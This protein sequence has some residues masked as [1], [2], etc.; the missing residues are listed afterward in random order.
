MKKSVMI[1]ISLMII[2]A[3]GIWFINIDRTP[4]ENKE[5]YVQEKI[6]NE[7]KNIILKILSSEDTKFGISEN[8][9][10]TLTSD[11]NLTKEEV[12]SDLIV[13]PTFDY[14]LEVVSNNEFKIKPNSKLERNA[15]YKFSYK[16]V[17]FGK[18]FQTA[19]DLKIFYSY[20]GDGVEDVPLTTGIEIYFNSENIV[21]LENHFTITPQVSG[22]FIYEKGKVIFITKGL[23]RDTIYTVKITSGISTE[24]NERTLEEPYEFTFTTG[25]FSGFINNEKYSV[26]NVLYGS[27]TIIP[28]STWGE[29][30]LYDVTILKSDTFADFKKTYTYYLENQSHGLEFED[31]DLV[32]DEE[33][34]S[35]SVDYVP[36]IDIPNNLEKGSYV[37]KINGDGFMQY[38]FL[39]VGDHQIY[40]AKAVN[41]ELL[42]I[43]D[44]TTSKPVLD[45]EVYLEDNVVGKTNFKGVLFLN[46]EVD[47]S[48]NNDYTVKIENSEY[49]VRTRGDDYGYYDGYYYDP[50]NISHDH[51]AFLY[52]DRSAYQSTDKVNIFGYVRSYTDAKISDAKI[53]VTKYWDDEVYL[54]KSVEVTDDYTITT[55]FDIENFDYGYYNMKFIIDGKIVEFKELFIV[56]YEKPEILLSSSIDKKIIFSGDV[57]NYNLNSSYFNG[58][59]YA[60]FDVKISQG[61]I[62]SYGVDVQIATTDKN[63]NLDLELTPV[64]GNSNWTPISYQIRAE[65]DQA[66]KTYLDIYEYIYVV[67]RNVMIQGSFTEDGSQVILDIETSNIDLSDFNG[68]FGVDYDNIKGSN[69]SKNIEIRVTETYF[70][71]VLDRTVYDKI[72][73]VYQDIYNYKKIDSDLGTYY[74][75]TENGLGKFKF[76]VEPDRNYTFDVSTRD[77]KTRKTTSSFRYGSYYRYDYYGDAQYEFESDGATYSI[78]EA[79]VKN[80]LNYGE[81]IGTKDNDL[82]LFLILR[83]G[84][85]D[86]IVTDEAKIEFEFERYYQPNVLIG[87]VYFDGVAM[88]IIPKYYKMVVEYDN[89]ELELN[90]VAKTDKLDYQPGE[91]VELSLDVIDKYGN[92]INGELN[93][94]V[95]DEAYLSLFEDYFDIGS[96]LHSRDY[97]D[98]LLFEMASSMSDEVGSG[99]ESGEGGDGSFIRADFKDTAAFETIKIVDGKGK[100]SFVLP[101]NLTSWRLT[102]H[103]VNEELYYGSSK[104][105]VN[106]KLPYFIRNLYDTVYLSGDN[107]FINLKSDGYDLN[108]DTPIQYTASIKDSKGNEKLYEKDY[109]GKEFANLPIGKLS[110]GLYELVVTGNSMGLKDGV[111]DEITVKDSFV[112]FKHKKTYSVKEDYVPNTDNGKTE[113]YFY[114]NEAREFQNTVFKSFGYDNIR[115]EEIIARFEAYDIL[116]NNFG[117]SG[118]YDTYELSEYQNWDG[119]LKELPTSDSSVISTSLVAATDYGMKYF[120]KERITEYLSYALVDKKNPEDVKAL[121]LWGLAK[122]NQPVLLGINTFL[123]SKGFEDLKFNSQMYII[124]ALL[125]IGEYN[126]AKD[127]S[128][129]TFDN[130]TK[131]NDA[132]TLKELLLARTLSRRLEDASFESISSNISEKEKN[133]AIDTYALEKVYDLKF[134]KREFKDTYMTFELDGETKKLSLPGT[135]SEKIT[136]S[137]GSIFKITDFVGD[138]YS[139]EIFHVIGTD[140]SEYGPNALEIKKT[141]LNKN[142]KQGDLIEV[143]IDIK[144]H[145]DDYVLIHDRI[146]SGFEYAGLGGD[147]PNEYWIYETINNKDINFYYSSKNSDGNFSYFIRAIQVGSYKAERAAIQHFFK[148]ELSFS[149]STLLKVDEND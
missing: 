6:E 32:F 83:N 128:I 119:G 76:T 95:V 64:I 55:S 37:V 99:A 98:G 103:A 142:I 69:V 48:L 12:I 91:K 124:Y 45:A 81:Q 136:V 63:G 147:L 90:V 132:L 102:L 114:N 133:K 109:K 123:E 29:Q 36:Y 78:G 97:Y 127:Y 110:E 18:A 79:V 149:N 72:H 14:D 137:E 146:P 40:Y 115:L 130:I 96:Q 148:E 66:E 111:K 24:D 138:V 80:I 26:L 10:F 42:W 35:I 16:N 107:V 62:Y 113:V 53:V 94:S 65:N 135:S 11:K 88:S 58:M 105:N 126:R 134:L 70:E 52:T 120:D 92:E 140:A 8:S 93:V 17:D 31:F 118:F 100:Y 59:P 112:D 60:N 30:K 75:K 73:K 82:A 86:Y 131:A 89:S 54:E 39:Q 23:S 9:Y 116:K 4:D 19:D 108:S 56:N 50:L 87:G 74:L 3:G 22:S 61:E 44:G 1:M 125:D 46:Y 104:I 144:K 33:L 101:D 117:D 121:L 145:P 34:T 57:V 20:P 13:E 28:L 38:V 84:I 15:V 27:E 2:V 43:L 139:S 67:P 21:D 77:S 47:Y 106:V 68:D 129:T 5:G 7:K 141:Y 41:G 49:I 143:N 85:L 122:Q 71:K 51:W 25:K